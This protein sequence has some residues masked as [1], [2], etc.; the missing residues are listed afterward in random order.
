MSPEA[1]NRWRTDNRTVKKRKTIKGS[2]VI[3]KTLHRKWKTEQHAPH[4][5]GDRRCRDRMVVRFTTTRVTSNP[6]H[7]EEYLL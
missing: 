1:I 6:A 2:T 7:G 5:K 4:Y 3:Y